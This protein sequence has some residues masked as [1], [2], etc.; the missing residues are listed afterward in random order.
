VITVNELG[1]AFY[2]MV[3]NATIVVS[4][5]C[6]SALVAAHADAGRPAG[7][8]TQPS[9][10]NGHV[11]VQSLTRGHGRTFVHVYGRLTLDQHDG[12]LAEH[13]IR[14][15]KIGH[16]YGEQLATC[17]PGPNGDFDVAV[18]TM[19]DPGGFDRLRLEIRGVQG[20][21]TLIDDL[22]GGLVE[23]P[24][25]NIVCGL[26]G[27]VQGT[28]QSSAGAPLAGVEIAVGTPWSCPWSTDDPSCLATAV[29]DSN[30]S[31]RI[32]AIPNGS[33]LIRAD[34]EQLQ[35]TTC[36]VHVTRSD[37]PTRA[38]T[39]TMSR[40]TPLRIMVSSGKGVPVPGANL[41]IALLTPDSR[42]SPEHLKWRAVSDGKGK[43]MVFGLP[44]G[45][46]CEIDAVTF[47]FYDE[48]VTV[49][50]EGGE[51]AILQRAAPKCSAYGMELG[52][53]CSLLRL[54]VRPIRGDV[55]QG[56]PS[57]SEGQRH[58]FLA[59]SPHVRIINGVWNVSLGK[60]SSRV[61]RADQYM[62]AAVGGE[63]LGFGSLQI[64]R[65][66]VGPAAIPLNR[67]ARVII[68]IEDTSS[69]VIPGVPVLYEAE[70][71]H[72]V[73]QWIVRSDSNGMAC[74][75]GVPSG[76]ARVS[77][78]GMYVDQPMDQI[79][80]T[81]ERQAMHTLQLDLRAMG[82][83]CS[84]AGD[85]AR[86]QSVILCLVSDEYVTTGDQYLPL[87]VRTAELGQTIVLPFYEGLATRI[88]GAFLQGNG[89]D[90][91]V[92]FPRCIVNAYAANHACVVDPR[93]E[94]PLRKCTITL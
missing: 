17:K 33:I 15:M 41:S 51:A 25:G 64:A 49:H 40:S 44:D 8:A 31:Y 57:D 74:F 75:E 92:S 80:A 34:E 43:A 91:V 16:T 54:A 29:T 73:D 93:H 65:E 52:D 68:R 79:V 72:I 42:R 22:P 1:R 46:E 7:P 84:V 62:W 47:G 76:T 4:L 81:S 50:H 28:V 56:L 12:A 20:I 60:F 55:T 36:V 2:T 39:I 66:T 83:E 26:P 67:S 3:W 38:P 10:V 24:L 61:E 45:G 11:P 9:C 14:L 94:L 88:V 70:R 32:D 37:G 58:V 35:S 89:S 82:I 87:Q 23:I 69:T 21:H 63:H 19:L 90:R 6:E 78:R 71:M 85:R 30:G 86:K 59:D 53:P 48:R 77:V 18:I 5:L 13:T 27:M